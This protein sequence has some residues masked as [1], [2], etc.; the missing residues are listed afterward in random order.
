MR[1]SATCRIGCRWPIAIALLA[2][3]VLSGLTI[4]TPAIHAAQA[5]DPFPKVY[6]LLR[7]IVPVEGAPAAPAGMLAAV[8][9]VLQGSFIGVSI[10][11]GSANDTLAALFAL[12]RLAG[13]VRGDTIE[14]YLPVPDILALAGRDEI[15]RIEAIVPP[16]AVK[17]DDARFAFASPLDLPTGSF[18]RGLEFDALLVDTKAASSNIGVRPGDDT[19]EDIF[20]KIVLNATRANIAGVWVSGRRVVS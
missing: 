18:C 9:P 6:G 7:H 16:Q 3:A 10:H 19:A 8:F 4:F 13:N 14:A 2:T 20:Q 15:R 12:G 17:G 1:R 11:T 5:P